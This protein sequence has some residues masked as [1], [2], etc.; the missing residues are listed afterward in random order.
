MLARCLGIFIEQTESKEKSIDGD[1]NEIIVR[2]RI[3]RH[4][5]EQENKRK[6]FSASELFKRVPCSF[7]HRIFSLL[8]IYSVYHI[9][10]G[11]VVVAVVV[12]T[13]HCRPPPSYSARSW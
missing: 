7:Y 8:P 12:A 1:T 10:V 11:V 6:P 13:A 9:L 4:L 2:C 5:D 3:Y